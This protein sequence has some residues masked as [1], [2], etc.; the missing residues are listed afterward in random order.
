MEDEILQLA[1]DLAEIL[2]EF[3]YMDVVAEVAAQLAE[4]EASANALL[5]DVTGSPAQRRLRAF[6]D[7][8]ERALVHPILFAQ[9]ALDALSEAEGGVINIRVQNDDGRIESDAIPPGAVTY[10]RRRD[11]PAR[12][13]DEV[14]V[15]DF[16]PQ[17][18]ELEKL[19]AEIR[20]QYDLGSEVDG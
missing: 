9:G 3:G 8:T 13:S 19:L 2:E 6:V 16:L 1:D 5:A 11:D 12:R 20:G 4:L 18:L 15:E 7:L 14:V 17:V 10:V